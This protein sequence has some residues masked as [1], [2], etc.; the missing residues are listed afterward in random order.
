MSGLILANITWPGNKVHVAA[1]A[2]LVA[3]RMVQQKGA[4]LAPPGWA[5]DERVYSWLLNA[6]RAFG[7]EG[8]LGRLR[9]LERGGGVLIRTRA[10]R[11]GH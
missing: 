1:E 4:M 10:R 9:L 3:G 2:L 5:R 6:A 7:V 11:T 8:R